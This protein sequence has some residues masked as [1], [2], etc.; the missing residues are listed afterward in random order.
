MIA[1][2]LFVMALA[3]FSGPTTGA[4]QQT[5]AS[6][7][8]GVTVTPA[9]GWS[10]AQD[11]WNVGPGAVSLQHA[12]V[13]AAFAAGSYSGTTQQLL[14]QQLGDLKA[15]FG[16]FRSLPPASTSI[17]EGVPAL[18]ML[19]SGTAD[20]GDLEGELV[21]GTIGGTGLVM[22]AVAPAGQVAQVQADLDEML[23]GLVIPR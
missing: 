20:S 13:L 9:A 23:N 21:V 11:V 10:S 5:P 19:F 4:A 8:Q 15:Q 6:L 7:R 3:G 17:A 22:L 12:G 1:W 18:K 16:S 14:D 2:M